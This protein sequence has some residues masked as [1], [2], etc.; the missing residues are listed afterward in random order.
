MLILSKERK[1]NKRNLKEGKSKIFCLVIH[2]VIPAA[3]FQ[4]EWGAL[5][6]E[7][8]LSGLELTSSIYCET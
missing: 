5:C 7:M 8:K 2:Y 4:W 1:R 3:P 6:P